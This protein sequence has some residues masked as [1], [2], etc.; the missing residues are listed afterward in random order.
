[1]NK[2]AHVFLQKYF[3]ISK[4]KYVFKEHSRIRLATIYIHTH[5][6]LDLI[7]W[8][9]SL[10]TRGLTL[11]Y[12]YYKYAL[13]CYFHSYE[14]HIS[15]SCRKKEMHNITVALVRIHKYHIY[16]E[17]WECYTMEAL[18][19]ILKTHKNSRIMVVQRTWDI[20]LDL[21]VLSFNCSRSKWRL[22]S[23]MVEGNMGKFES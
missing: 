7:V 9:N 12:M 1:M 15:L 19:F 8:L 3:Q 2:I 4:E 23:P 22:R 21:I 5:I 10:W 20:V 18:S 14:L 11:Q 16:W 17:T 13:L 6:H